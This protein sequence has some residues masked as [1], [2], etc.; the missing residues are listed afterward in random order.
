MTTCM[1]TSRGFAGLLGTLLVAVSSPSARAA[2]TPC[3]GSWE[4]SSIPSARADHHLAFDAARGRT[5]M[6]GGQE[7]TGVLLNDTW[8]WD[9][10]KW[11][12]A[13]TPIAPTARVHGAMA[14]DLARQRVVLFGGQVIGGVNNRETWE[15][16]GAAWLLRSTTGP[17]A[18]FGHT[19]VYDSALQRVVV[20]GGQDNSNF[21]GDSWS[22]DGVAGV[23]SQIS[24][25]V[26][27]GQGSVIGHQH[28][29]SY[30]SARQRHVLF[31][32]QGGAVT[33]ERAGSVWSLL[34]NQGPPIGPAGRSRGMMLFDPSVGIGGSSVLFGG[35]GAGATDASVWAWNGLAWSIAQPASPTGP[36]AREGH[37]M[38]RDS[39]RGAVVLFGGSNPG[40]GV[41]SANNETW[42][43][44][45]ATGWR[46]LTTP[47]PRESHALAY[48]PVYREVV[49]FGGIVSSGG[50]VSQET[51]TRDSSGWTR[52]LVA[53]PGAMGG[54]YGHVM[55]YDERAQRVVLFGGR[56]QGGGLASAG[57]WEWD[58]AQW[59]ARSSAQTPPARTN[60]AMVY[61]RGALGV[62][63]TVLA[64]GV[65]SNGAASTDTW[66]W[67]GVTGQWQMVGTLPSPLTGHGMAYDSRDNVIVAWGG[68]TSAGTAPSISQ[69]RTLYRLDSNLLGWTQMLPGVG[70]WPAPRERHAMMFDGSTNTTVM[71]GGIA[72]D[73][74][75]G[76]L[77]SEVW[78]WD[79]RLQQWS[80]R[81]SSGDA[82]PGIRRHGVAADTH[83]AEIVVF[84]GALSANTAG[85]G[86]AS[87]RTQS[88]WR[89]A[90]PRT[91]RWKTFAG[92]NYSNM[93][94][95]EC[96]RLPGVESTIVVERDGFNPALPGGTPAWPVNINVASA[97]VARTLDV[98]WD[99]VTFNLLQGLSLLAPDDLQDPSLVVGGSGGEISVLRVINTNLASATTTLA[100]TAGI[101]G[102]D[103]GADGTLRVSGQR[104][105]FSSTGDLVIGL[106]GEGEAIIEDRAQMLFGGAGTQLVV[107][108]G[109]QGTLRVT[110]PGARAQSTKGVGASGA[111]VAG[112]NAGSQGLIAVQSG[113]VF[114]ADVDDF[115][116]GDAGVGT[117]EV[118]GG[119]ALLQTNSFNSAVVGRGAG[120]TGVVRVDASEWREGV[121]VPTIGLG[122]TGRVEL[123]FSGIMGD[124]G[125]SI[126][127]KGEV[128]GDGR[129]VGDVF[130]LGHVW[131]DPSSAIGSATRGRIE[132]LGD[133]RQIGLPPGASAGA[134]SGRLTV[135][136]S[137]AGAGEASELS[138]SGA[139]QLAGA[140]RVRLQNGFLPEAGY[141]K[142]VVTGATRAGTTFDVAFLP[143][144]P[145]D[146]FMRVVYGGPADNSLVSLEVGSLAPR[147]SVPGAQAASAP[148]E[149]QGAVGADIN[150]DGL[151][152]AVLIT[153]GSPGAVI[154]LFS[155]G[156]DG[157][158]T[159]L[160]FWSSLQLA[161][162][163]ASV[164]VV[165][166]DLDGNPGVD[167]AVA[168]ASGSLRVFINNND[169]Q[170]TGSGVTGS[171]TPR[172][173]VQ[174]LGDLSS[175]AGGDLN[176][177]GLVD[178]ALTSETGGSVT[179]LRGMGG[180]D[181]TQQAPLMLGAS[182]SPRG[183]DIGDLDDDKDLRRPGIAVGGGGGLQD[184]PEGSTGRL[185]VLE[186]VT[187]VAGGVITFAPAQSF[188]V[189]G[190]VKEVL[191]RN[192]NPASSTDLFGEIVAVVQGADTACVVVLRNQGSTSGLVLSPPVAL[193][194]G[195]E[196]TSVAS[197]DLDGDDDPDLAVA[198]KPDS[199]SDRRVRVLRSEVSQ[200]SLLAF[201]QAPD[202]PNP[203][204]APAPTLVRA[205]DI[206][207]DGRRDLVAIRPMAGG[208]DGGPESGPLTPSIAVRVN[209]AIDGDANRDG[210]IDFLDLNIVLSF[211]GQTG[212]GLG[213]DVNGDGRVDFLDLNIVLS[214]FGRAA[215]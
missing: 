202:L 184:G 33:W 196:A 91:S 113:A 35:G 47:S 134:E 50:S 28:M 32:V 83:R 39:A 158:G 2:G 207:G 42:E 214:H 187:P 101:I 73:Q 111:I 99:S 203:A 210:F 7:S 25:S 60:F 23:W 215:G 174:G 176:D 123:S 153:P 107:G 154:V 12:Q 102:R 136:L 150:G 130:N 197:L 116:V 140:L 132:V 81:T 17:S 109:G 16:D 29:S 57:M 191:I 63:Q 78:E 87:G 118:S 137:G 192:L 155:R 204:S 211:F 189:L 190:E 105:R 30:D 144:F 200:G 151:D 93:V 121:S 69:H 178:L 173:P 159:F 171:F 104:V 94:N 8:T 133:Y 71:I 147:L 53:A 13:S 117:V 37:A 138:A 124:R 168:D 20:F 10:L 208:T 34:S 86:I 38:A 110:G 129:I 209:R 157:S 146:R 11:R 149:I 112:Q 165:A 14:Y 195:S 103:I 183:V 96:D 9:G 19:M 48:D 90:S 114:L 145:D 115:I 97:Q 172:A 169:W 62:G 45:M 142:T 66:A 106:N 143:G 92:G 52:R 119:N 198:A 100:T 166:K 213:G 135:D 162:G 79:N 163:N 4:L 193:E 139:A 65:L 194:I 68:R 54:R 201:S 98:R 141:S 180:G 1:R 126:A 58:G 59:T 161:V 76:V 22:W 181:F 18:R 24:T 27:P 82:P 5:V 26:T 128:R 122:G 15:W 185:F 72:D 179:I 36:T 188:S 88:E 77:Y 70:T 186:N 212:A 31:S 160:G 108:Q 152:D 49:L 40:G 41:A 6:F 199:V 80:L 56:L 164:G 205:W 74:N 170:T 43:W 55:V 120:S 46:N 89:F 67:D 64:G 131:P 85:G 167:I 44:S 206:S 182:S 127:S 75:A 21:V 177:D 95:W 156:V 148:S 84:G 3:A 125:A 61:A 175:M 51:W